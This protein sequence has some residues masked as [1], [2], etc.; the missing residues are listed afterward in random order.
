MKTENLLKLGMALLMLAL[1]LH[2]CG[3]RV[4]SVEGEYVYYAPENVTIEEAKRT[5]LERARIQALADAFGTVVSQTGSVRVHNEGEKSDVDFV[6]VGGSEVKGEWIETCG[7]PAYT[8]TYEQGMLVVKVAVK[9]KAREITRAGV[10]IQTEILRNGIDT[11]CAGTRFRHGDE[12]YLTFL[13]PVSGYLA[14]YLVDAQGMAYCLLP[15][16]GQKDGIYQVEANHEYVLFC[17]DK[18]EGC[19]KSCVDEYVMTCERSSEQNQIYI[20]F[21]PNPF[22]KAADKSDG[23]GTLPRELSFEKFEKWQQA[24]KRRDAALQSKMYLIEVAR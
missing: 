2:V 14:V 17:K 12:L 20:L 24:Q 10:D 3:Q 1:P 9:G 5:A 15:Y 4:K 11:K 7:E 19:D 13:S 8:V 23:S 18:A 22:T 21:S 16:S 6:S